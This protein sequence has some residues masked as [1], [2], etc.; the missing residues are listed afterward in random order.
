MVLNLGELEFFVKIGFFYGDG[1]FKIWVNGRGKWMFLW[2]EV[3]ESINVCVINIL[4]F[5]RLIFGFCK[6]RI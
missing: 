4:Y 1:F 2:V 3:R 6:K 5:N